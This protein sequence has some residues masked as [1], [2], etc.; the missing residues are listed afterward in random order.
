MLKRI[1][2]YVIIIITF[3]ILYLGVLPLVLTGAVKELCKTVTA[4]SNYTVNIETP[5][6]RFSLLPTGAFEA[7][8]ITIKQ[9]NS[10]DK[11]Q[12]KDFKIK[13][14]LLPLL[15]GKLHINH[16]EASELN[17]TSSIKEN[18]ELDKDF[19]SNLETSRIK[20]DSAKIS[21]FKILIFQKDIKKP[22]DYSGND[23][24]YQKQNRYLKIEIHSKLEIQNK[25]SNTNINLYLPK[26]NDIKKTVFE[27]NVSN[28]SLEPLRIY[29][30]H[31]LP[32]DLISLN[33]TIN[34][35][36]NKGELITRL[37]NCSAI[38]K[39]SSKSIILPDTM[40]IKSKF[41]IK[42]ERIYFENVDINSKNIL[43]QHLLLHK[44]KKN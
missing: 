32:K 44:V 4:D 13:V 36:A 5:S 34:M 24:T 15:A 29:F 27:V 17:I 33:G 31:Y 16:T 3:Y 42:R 39:N 37:D 38:M 25:I 1:N 6:F 35:E 18:V 8:D 11:F 7:K 30:R 2:K 21:K 22:I 43:D 41:N 26:N 12:I 23:F 9:K 40:S 28:L 14:R 19:F 20:L 10:I